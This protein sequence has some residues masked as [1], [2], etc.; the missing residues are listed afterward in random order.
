VTCLRHAAIVE[1]QKSV[2]KLRS[3]RESG[4]YSVPF[5]TAGGCAVPS[6]ATLHHARFK[7]NAVVNTL[8]SPKSTLCEPVARHRDIT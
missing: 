6:R 7:G 5:R 3:N 4:V 1:A 8:T 2:N